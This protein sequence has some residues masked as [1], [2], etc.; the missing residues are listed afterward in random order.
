MT[1]SKNDSDFL[2]KVGEHIDASYQIMT[3]VKDSECLSPE[4]WSNKKIFVANKTDDGGGKSKIY[5]ESDQYRNLFY[6]LRGNEPKSVYFNKRKITIIEN[7]EILYYVEMN[8]RNDIYA[9]RYVNSNCDNLIRLCNK[10]NLTL[11]SA[12]DNLGTV[13]YVKDHT[14]LLPDWAKDFLTL[15]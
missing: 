5:Y 11:K 9:K 3:R 4:G 15:S 6:L 1:I 2:Q 13:P 8:N 14:E 12:L 10:T 7:C